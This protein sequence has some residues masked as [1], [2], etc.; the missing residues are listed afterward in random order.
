MPWVLYTPWQPLRR[1]RGFR[2]GGLG[3]RRRDHTQKPEGEAE[4]YEMGKEGV[5]GSLCPT[6]QNPLYVRDQQ[7]RPDLCICRSPLRPRALRPQ[8][9]PALVHTPLHIGHYAGA[10]LD[11]AAMAGT[12]GRSGW[13]SAVGTRRQTHFSARLIRKPLRRASFAP[14]RLD[15]TRTATTGRM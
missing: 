7:M 10:Q 3:V 6:P 15:I 8:A 13:R 9:A 14:G 12:P 2:T 4:S 5:C 11:S 1:G